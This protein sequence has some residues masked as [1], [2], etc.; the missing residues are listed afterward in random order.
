MSFGIC[1]IA[2]KKVLED[3]KSGRYAH[4]TLTGIVMDRASMI[5][6]ITLKPETLTT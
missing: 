2:N 5:I 1:N 4:A 3:S 6:G